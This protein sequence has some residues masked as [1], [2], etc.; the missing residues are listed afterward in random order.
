MTAALDK[1]S[2]DLKKAGERQQKV[3]N[4]K[5]AG[6]ALLQGPKRLFNKLFHIKD[7]IEKADDNRRKAFFL[8]PGYRKHIMRNL[9]LAI[10]YGGA[11]HTKLALFPV[12][13]I[14][15]HF[16][17]EK[18]RRI[19]NELNRE[20]TAELQIIDEKINDANSAGDNHEKYRLMRLRKKVESEK[21]RVMLNSRYI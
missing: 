6:N 12:T 20:L 16:S 21:I 8:K 15:R 10:L 9:K 17:K 11:I 5:T 3:D 4:L 18:D 7:S 2:R 13:L 1:E 14:C 19:R